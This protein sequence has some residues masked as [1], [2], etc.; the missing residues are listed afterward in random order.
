M[1][2]SVPRYRYDELMNIGWKRILP[3]TTS[4]LV[5]SASILYFNN[6]LP[7]LYIFTSK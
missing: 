5:T 1:R 7:S 2:A 4:C 3:S 6:T